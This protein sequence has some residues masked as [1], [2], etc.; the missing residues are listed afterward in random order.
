LFG[1]DKK[2]LSLSYNNNVSIVSVTIY[3]LNNLYFLVGK[4]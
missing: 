2:G 1:G 4:H 3:I